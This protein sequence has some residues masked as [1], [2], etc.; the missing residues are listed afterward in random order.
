MSQSPTHYDADLYK[1]YTKLVVR[2]A[3]HPFYTCAQW[4]AEASR[5]ESERTLHPPLH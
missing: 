2:F 4:P 5:W 3:L 1:V